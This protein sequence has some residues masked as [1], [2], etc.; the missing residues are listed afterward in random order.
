[1]KAVRTAAMVRRGFM[2]FREEGLVDFAGTFFPRPARRGF[3][4]SE[5]AETFGG[6]GEGE[7]IGVG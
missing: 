7:Y 5:V 1:M 3:R 6:Q 4:G 2:G